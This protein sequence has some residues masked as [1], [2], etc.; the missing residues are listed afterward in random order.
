MGIFWV[1]WENNFISSFW[2]KIQLSSQNVS[3]FVPVCFVPF[4]THNSPYHN[5]G[6]AQT[7]HA[8][9]PGDPQKKKTHLWSTKSVTNLYFERFRTQKNRAVFWCLKRS[10]I[11]VFDWVALLWS[12]IWVCFIVL[13]DIASASFWNL[14]SYLKHS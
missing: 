14:E 5:T 10:K 6:A 4:I 13:S 2:G 8:D 1:K 3:W 12:C 11:L 7:M 9:I